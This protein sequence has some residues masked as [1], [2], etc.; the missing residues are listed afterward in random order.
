MNRLL[1]ATTLATLSAAGAGQARADQYKIDP[2]H[3]FVT[4]EV[5]HFGTSTN[6]GRFDK[7]DGSIT[8]DDTTKTG[9][10]E[11]T[12]DMH[13]ID[14]GIVKL[15][16]HLQSKEFFN[17]DQFPTATFVGDKFVFDGDKVSSVSGTLT[18]LGVSQ[19]ITLKAVNYNCYASPMLHARVCGGDFET[20]FTRSNFGMTGLLPLVP[21]QVHLLIE[22]EAVKQ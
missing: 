13:S 9:H 15:D 7:K 20:T 19:P 11:I 4:Y 1:L 10:A 16:Q 22:V 12:I 14:T 3:T 5:R 6:R 8:L 2:N 17:A 18:L 21:D